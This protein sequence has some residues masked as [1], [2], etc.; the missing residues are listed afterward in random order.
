MVPFWR[1]K[2]T[3]VIFQALHFPLPFSHPLFFQ[4]PRW[5]ICD[6]FDD[7]APV[8]AYAPVSDFGHGWPSG[9]TV[10]LVSR[11]GLGGFQVGIFVDFYPAKLGWHDV[12]LTWHMFIKGVGLT[13]G[14]IN[15]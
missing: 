11:G 7:T 6:R 12:N 10:C 14:L 15:E 5:K 4:T 1:L 9:T 3:K 2:Y 13:I 8:F